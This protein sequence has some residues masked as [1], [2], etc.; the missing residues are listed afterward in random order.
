MANKFSKN[1]IFYFSILLSTFYFLLSSS[2]LGAE[3]TLKK[4]LEVVGKGDVFDIVLV[5]DTEMEVVNAVEASLKYSDNL[6]IENISDGNSIINL[7]VSKPAVKNSKNNSIV[8]SGLIPGGLTIKEGMILTLTFRSLSEGEGYVLVKDAKILRNDSEA[9]ETEVVL[10]NLEFNI[11][12]AR[13]QTSGGEKLILDFLPP[14]AFKIYLSKNKDIFGNAW[15]IS[16]NAQDKGSGINHYEARERFLGLFGS[17]KEAE[18][19]YQLSHQSLFGII[20]VRAVDNVGRER[21]VTFVPVRLYFL[22]GGLATLL[23][24]LL[25]YKFRKF[26]ISHT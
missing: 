10:R 4:N 21:T 19:P 8:L 6:R 22:Y 7:W 17:W 20:E 9:S 1:S 14:D 12:S 5:I 25:I 3:L 23:I 16:F 24:G 18:S 15:F 26:I 11:E 13:T 2:A